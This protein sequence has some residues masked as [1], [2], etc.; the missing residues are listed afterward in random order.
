M[1]SF[2]QTLDVP[3]LKNILFATD[4]SPCSEAALPYL[5][6]I[7]EHYASTIHVVHVIPPEPMLELPLDFPPELDSDQ[8]VARTWIKNMLTTKPFGKAVSTLTVERGSFWPVISS[9]IAE[10]KIDLIVLG[11]HGRRGLKKMMLGSVAEQVFRQAMCPVMTVGPLAKLTEMGTVSHAKILFATDFS[12]GSEQAL[13]YAIAMSRIYQ[14]HLM[15]LHVVPA[16]V[17]VEPANVFDVGA[18]TIQISTGLMND[19]IASAQRQVENL[20]SPRIMHEL[21]PEVLV[22]CGYA[23]DAILKIAEEKHTDL[24]VMG[25]HRASQSTLVAHLPWAT[26]SAIVCKAHCPV[27]T[28]RS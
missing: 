25:A 1:S 4:F 26:A 17:D 9:V 13:P 8:A 16:E 15:V 7:A 23:A 28:V 12:A 20:L 3:S 18:A 11:T 19:S 24:I 6:D 10:K 14:S 5:R 2:A 21:Q 27:L 22:E